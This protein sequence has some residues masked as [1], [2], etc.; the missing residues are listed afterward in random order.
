MS[1]ATRSAVRGVHSDG[2]NTIVFPVARAGASF[3]ES[4]QIGKFHGTIW[5]TTPML[6]A[7]AFHMKREEQEVSQSDQTK[8]IAG[9]DNGQGGL[10]GK[11]QN[12]TYGS[13]RVYASFVSFT[14]IVLP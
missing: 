7:R 9:A 4:I 5:P 2:L 10:L 12:G 1:S 8:G 13:T 14:S 11:N 6:V 3:H